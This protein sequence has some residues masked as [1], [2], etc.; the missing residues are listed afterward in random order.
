MVAV[1]GGG[2]GLVA[3]GEDF[4][5]S[6]P[7]VWTSPDGTTWSLLPHDEA[8][9]PGPEG[10][11]GG[12]TV[13]SVTAGGPGL[14][15]VGVD[16]SDPES[17]RAAVWVSPDGLAWSQIPLSGEGFDE[18]QMV[19]VTVG[20][21][22]LVAIGFDERSGTA[23][24][25]SPEGEVWSRVPHDE[26]LFGGATMVAVT[27]GGPG[28]VAVGRDDLGAAVWT[29]PDGNT[30]SRIPYDE[31]VFGDAEL[32]SVT[33]GGAGL[34]AV[35]GGAVEARTGIGA[36][37]WTSRDGVTWSRVPQDERVFA[38]PLMLSV[39]AGGPGLVAVG[40]GAAVWTSPD[41]VTWSRTFWEEPA[42]PVE[43]PRSTVTVAEALLG[44]DWA[45][46]ELDAGQFCFPVSECGDPLGAWVTPGDLEEVADIVAADLRAEGFEVGMAPLINGTTVLD[47]FSD[48]PPGLVFIRLYSSAAQAASLDPASG[49]CPPPSGALWNCQFIALEEGA[50]AIVAYTIEGVG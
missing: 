19:A 7:A 25:T 33:A 24:W 15:A 6:R 12:V 47:V 2:P 20:G 1:T 31:S 4:R 39:V 50:V 18:A 32:K 22:G 48:V 41:G 42:Q 28:L 5:R 17:Q 34:V 10:V 3:V 36:A 40:F 44:Y 26:A 35:G 45:P 11:S 43:R 27:A 13:R 37:V 38:G 8:V 21:P 49:L 46:V 9:F 29:S 16:F 30:W 14:V 23:V